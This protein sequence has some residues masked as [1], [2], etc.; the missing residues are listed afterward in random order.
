MIVSSYLIAEIQKNVY[1]ML[2][3]KGFLS[4]T[5]LIP[6]FKIGGLSLLITAIYWVAY[7]YPLKRKVI[8]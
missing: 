4:V 1:G 3:Q 8:I 6:I 5:I 7:V 2:I